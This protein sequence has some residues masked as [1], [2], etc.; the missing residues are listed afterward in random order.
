MSRSGGTLL[1][2]MRGSTTST[3]T[4][5]STCDGESTT[6][7]QHETSGTIIYFRFSLLFLC[8]FLVITL[9]IISFIFGY[10]FFFSFF[11]CKSVSVPTTT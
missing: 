4:R 11:V 7:Q 10:N 9:F 5:L 3:P 2:M 1:L 6:N 8:F